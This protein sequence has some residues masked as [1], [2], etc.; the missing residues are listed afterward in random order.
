M[1]FLSV[2]PFLFNNK[3]FWC[4]MGETYAIENDIAMS[5]LNNLIRCCSTV[6]A[7]IFELPLSTT[8]GSAT[9]KT[10]TTQLL[11]EPASVCHRAVCAMVPSVRSAENHMAFTLSWHSLSARF[12]CQVKHVRQIVHEAANDSASDSHE[13]AKKYGRVTMLTM[14]QDAAARKGGLRRIGVAMHK[15]RIM[16][17]T[18]F[19][20]LAV[21]AQASV[22]GIFKPLLAKVSEPA[23]RPAKS[24]NKMQQ[25]YVR[26][27][28]MKKNHALLSIETKN[29]DALLLG[30][31]T[32]K[33]RKYL[34]A[35]IKL[36]TTYAN[37]L[38]IAS[39]IWQLR[40]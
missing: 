38:Q 12:S 15:K 4:E 34:A 20:K 19:S 29:I 18:A 5:R 2:A 37:R 1:T 8:I 31:K 9:S 40:K 11:K 24:S 35:S 36:A 21:D 17:A 32:L 10:R 22:E 3:A 13:I 39:A 7:E 14:I 30:T 23:G 26:H 25:S 27:S 6:R 28:K 16:N 33:T